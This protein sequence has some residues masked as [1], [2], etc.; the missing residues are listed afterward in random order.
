MTIEV[1]WFEVNKKGEVEFLLSDGRRADFATLEKERILIP[2]DI[3]DAVAPNIPV[4]SSRFKA[5][6]AEAP[7]E[8]SG[9]GGVSYQEYLKA[10]EEARIK[11]LKSERENYTAAMAEITRISLAKNPNNPEAQAAALNLA[12]SVFSGI[13]DEDVG[14][15]DAHYRKAGLYESIVAQAADNSLDALTNERTQRAADEYDKFFIAP[16]D[17]EIRAAD[18]LGNQTKSA[19]LK[20]SRSIVVGSK[21]KTLIEYEEWVRSSEGT[22]LMGPVDPHGDKAITDLATFFTKS[23]PSFVLGVHPDLPAWSS[24]ISS[25]SKAYVAAA[26]VRGQALRAEAVARETFH[27]MTDPLAESLLKMSFNGS[28]DSATRNRLMQEFVIQ[29]NASATHNS[30]LSIG[31]DPALL[32]ASAYGTALR[33]AFGGTDFAPLINPADPTGSIAAINMELTRRSNERT[34]KQAQ[35]QAVLDSD[36]ATPEQKA[37]AAKLNT[38]LMS[39]ASN[40]DTVDISGLDKAFGATREGKEA[41]LA[42]LKGITVLNGYSPK[43]EARAK[44]MMKTITDGGVPDDVGIK[45]FTDTAGKTRDKNVALKGI[46]ENPDQTYNQRQVTAAQSQLEGKYTP[47]FGFDSDVTNETPGADL[48]PGAEQIFASTVGNYDFVGPDGKLVAGAPTWKDFDKEIRTRVSVLIGKYPESART[49]ELLKA[50]Q[51]Q[52]LDQATSRL[53]GYLSTSGI[54]GATST[55]NPGGTPAG[56]STSTTPAAAPTSAGPARGP[57]GVILAPGEKPYVGVA[58]TPGGITPRTKDEEA[59]IADT[60]KKLRVN[61]KTLKDLEAAGGL[62]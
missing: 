54:A 28:F 30:V 52:A 38:Q 12:Q 16:L 42:A 24:T 13:S 10:Q 34:K 47:S 22:H 20:V 39:P 49:P 21:A 29:S 17:T 57:N 51:Q 44:A 43:D 5:L 23:L 19:E 58:S 6:V 35:L 45:A 61:D 2:P 15:L 50:I 60:D 41:S 4:S 55:P 33:T 53:N 18:D 32:A 27:T 62:P 40:P 8:Q 31:M 9:P 56:T 59:V 36:L 26:M 7:G 46:M 3:A 48:A 25:I 1:K 37:E 11:A 14:V